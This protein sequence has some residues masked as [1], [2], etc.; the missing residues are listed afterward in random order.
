MFSMFDIGRDHLLPDW[1]LRGHDL[2]SGVPYCYHC[3]ADRESME[4]MLCMEE[5][6]IALVRHRQCLY[7]PRDS[8]YKRE[9][10]KATTGGEIAN[11]LNIP[12]T[13]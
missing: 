9:D 7:N 11:E 6:I 4:N 8:N 1:L 13:C 12:G 5:R 3:T 10:I 2:E